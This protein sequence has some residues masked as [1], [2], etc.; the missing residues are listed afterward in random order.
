MK[1]DSDSLSRPG[2]RGERPPGFRA[3][4]VAASR[5]AAPII[6]GRGGGSL[7]RLKAE[8]V[9]IVGP[10]WADLAWPDALGRGGVLRVR[11]LPAAALDLQ[12]RAPLLL[13]RINMF[14]GRT[15][16]TRLALVQ[17]P[18]PLPPLART[19]APPPLSATAVEA[20]D[21]SL[22]EVADPKLREALARLGRS[23]LRRSE[24][25]RR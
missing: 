11:V 2:G 6:A 14:F 4:G 16:A 15:V 13:E 22:A 3:L 23:V 25:E 12:H 18:L 21:R 20:L 24:G 19:T 5:L 17:G 7:A 10:E 1:G 9:A 8:W